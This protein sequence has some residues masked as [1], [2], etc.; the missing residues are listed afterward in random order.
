MDLAGTDPDGTVDQVTITT[1]PPV[2]EGILHLADGTTPV[3]AAQAATLVFTPAA[4]FNG[5]VTISF[6]VTDNDGNV[7]SSTNEVSMVNSVNDVPLATDDIAQTEQEHP[8]SIDLLS[9]DYDPEGDLISVV[10]AASPNGTVAINPDGS[11]TFQPAP[12]FSGSAVINYT[13]SDGNAGVHSASV[14]VEVRAAVHID[15]AS[16]S[17]PA[18][19]LLSSTTS[20]PLRAEGAVLDAI[21]DIQ[22]LNG[23]PNDVTEL[24]IVIAAANQTSSLNGIA[25]SDAIG[26]S[27]RSQPLMDAR[28]WVI[29]QALNNAAY[30]GTNDSWDV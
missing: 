20:E 21:S 7:S 14:S 5:T 10:S 24:G 15:P 4:N 26:N 3:V 25:A 17:T 2:A 30:Q 23:I 27:I 6:T 18:D 12:G 16:P 19:P 13:I 28:T 22:S 11:L 8:V 1:L 29:E 9:N